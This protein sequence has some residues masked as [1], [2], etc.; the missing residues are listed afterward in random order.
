M[1]ACKVLKFGMEQLELLGDKCEED[2]LS[3]HYR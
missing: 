1:I 3:G 2:D